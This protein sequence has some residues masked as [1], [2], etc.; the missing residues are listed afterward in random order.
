[1]NE[2]AWESFQPTYAQNTHTQQKCVNLHTRPFTYTHIHTHTHAHKYT[3]THMHIH[4]HR[5]HTHT[6][7][8]TT[9]NT[10]TH[11]HTHKHKPTHTQEME[12]KALG[13]LDEYFPT[14]I[15]DVSDDVSGVIHIGAHVGQ[16]A[17]WYYSKVRCP[18]QHQPKICPMCNS[19]NDSVS[20]SLDDYIYQIYINIHIIYIYIYIYICVCV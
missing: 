13:T 10:H 18:A 20:P 5:T 16:E 4:T 12:A 6:N 15:S 1:M 19:I 14:A 3:H 7:T 2:G 11:T 17:G 8:H 9:T